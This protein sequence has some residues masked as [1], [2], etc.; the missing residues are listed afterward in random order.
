M[1]LTN[2]TL[3]QRYEK[4]SKSTKKNYSLIIIEFHILRT[5]MK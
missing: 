4:T 2:I 3:I 1:N 5:R